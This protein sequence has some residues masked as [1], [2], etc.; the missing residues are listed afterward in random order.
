MKHTRQDHVDFKLL[1]E[2]APGPDPDAVADALQVHRAHGRRN[3]TFLDFVR[4]EAERL[5]RF[6]LELG[7]PNASTSRATAGA[8]PA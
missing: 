5:P 2:G 6:R 8:S 4:G 1:G 7:T 3:G